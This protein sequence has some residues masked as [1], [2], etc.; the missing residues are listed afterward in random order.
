[1]CT[2]CSPEDRNVTGATQYNFSSVAAGLRLLSL[3]RPV[4]TAGP[5][6]H[7]FW[8]GCHGSLSDKFT[9][10]IL[11]VQT[12]PSFWYALGKGCLCDQPPA[13]T[14]SFPCCCIFTAKR[15]GCSEQPLAGGWAP[16]EGYIHEFLQNPSVFFLHW[17]SSTPYPHRI[18]AVDLSHNYNVTVSATRLSSESPTWRRSQGP[19]QTQSSD[20]WMLA[21]PLKKL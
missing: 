8:E 13:K 1:M 7:E 14:L 12:W 20:R 10:P 19:P 9:V 21:P 15:R 11:S 16:K 4:Y 18:T 3:E 5:Q 17:D 2:Y 6:E